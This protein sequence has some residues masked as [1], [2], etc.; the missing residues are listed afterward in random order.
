MAFQKG[1][2]YAL[3]SKSEGFDRAKRYHTCLDC[4]YS[5]GDIWKICP[6]CGSKN[7]QYFMSQAELQRGMMLLT[8]QRAG[9][10]SALRF[11]PRYDLKVNGVKVA[12]YTA[13]AEYVRDGVVVYEDTKPKDFIDDYARLKMALFEAIYGVTVTIPQRESGNRH[14]EKPQF[15][16]N[17]TERE[18]S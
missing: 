4:R 9:A 11:Q 8:L 6:S 17:Q 1:N 10:I 5:Q 7:R 18:T 15:L 16:P 12:A 13:D 2:K 3:K 14:R